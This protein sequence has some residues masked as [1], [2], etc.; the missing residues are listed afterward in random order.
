MLVTSRK[1]KKHE[2][3]LVF[4]GGTDTCDKILGVNMRRKFT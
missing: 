2:V 4:D 3:E 1:T